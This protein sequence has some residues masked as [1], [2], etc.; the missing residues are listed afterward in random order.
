MKATLA[1]DPNGVEYYFTCTAGGGNDSGWQPGV[2]YTD[3][4]LSELTTYTYSVKARDKSGNLN[5]TAPSAALPATTEDG[6][7][8]SPDPMTWATAPYATGPTSVAMVATTATDVSDVEYYFTCTAGGGNDSG[9][10][11][12]STYIDFELIEL[13][14]YTYT[15]KA[16]DLSSNFNETAPSPARSTDTSDTT[17]PV[18]NPMTWLTVPYATGTSSISMTATT[19]SDPSGIEYYFTCTTAGGNDSGWQTS[20][21]YED[22]GLNELASYS[23][24][25]KARDLSG[26]LNETFDSIELSATTLDGTA[27]TPDPMTWAT[28]PHATG[29]DSISMTATIATDP[30]GIEYYFTCTA[31]GG[32]DSGWQPGATYEDTGLSDLTSYSYTA[33]A[34][35]LSI[36][37][38]ETVDSGAQSATTQDGTGPLPNAMT[39]AIPPHSTG[40]SS[41]SMTATTATDVSGVEYY[42]TC[43]AGGGNDSG[44]QPGTTYE[45][46]G[47]ND[48]T[49]Y[50]Y[51]VKARD[52]SVNLNETLT[53][54]ALS[55]T[56]DDGTPPAP[57]PMTWAIMPYATSATTIS[58]TATPATDPSGV[59]Y[60]FANINDPNHDSGWQD[61]IIYS[62]TGL[63]QRTMYSY[64][65]TARDKSSNQNQTAA[66]SVQSATTQDGS[67]PTP[68]PMTWNVEP[69]ADSP[70]SISM[71]AT[72]AVDPNGVEYY[73]AN[74]TD[75]AHD[76]G[77]QNGTLYLDAGLSERTEYTYTVMARDKSINQNQTAPS[78]AKSA[79]TED[80]TPPTPDPMT[81][82]TEPFAA[83]PYSI[84][85]TATTAS[86]PNGVQYYFT[87]TAGGG[88]DSG[89]QDISDYTD[90]GLNDLTL[91]T[92][93]VTARDKSSNL[94]ET[95]PSVA[96]SATTEDGTA[97]DPDPATWATAPHATGPYSISM[98][99]T[100]A[101]DVSGVEYY[102][103]CTAGGGNDSGWQPDATYED[104]GLND[105]TACTYTVK[106]RDL[107]AGLNETTD[108]VA[109]SATTEDGT[110]PTPDPM[111][112]AIPPQSTGTSS[113]SMTATTATDPS[114]VEY[115]FTCT[116]G[117]GNDSGWQPGETYEDIG[118]ND[119]SSYTYTVTARDKSSNQ[120]PTAAS[121]AQSA[122]TLDGTLP[123]P[124]PMT[125][126]T[127]PYATGPDS[128]SMMATTA[129]DLSGVEYY[130]TCTAGGGND[131][132]WQPEATY[133]DS[134][135]SEITT[136]TYT[137]SARDLSP[138]QNRTAESSAQSATTEDG[139]KPT[140][141][142][143][144]WAIVPHATST[145][146]ISMTA[147]TA[148]DASGVEY[149]FT[150]T[151]GGGNNSGWQPGATYE[152]TGLSEVTTYTYTVM[153]RD[154]S[155]NR[156]QT[157][158]SA[159]RSA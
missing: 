120:N 150:C 35:D 26:N 92:Y 4:G 144:T 46:T 71:T 130:F 154:L 23:Y 56:T 78:A 58:M 143:M 132:G 44:W 119:L 3:T 64:T 21:T 126:A 106:A 139:T 110:S 91:Y 53:S 12:S 121:N 133:V 93:T 29:P 72:T 138:N 38:N 141:N 131:S 6:T 107:S 109:L 98:T 52:L 104:T 36:N 18:P 40:T 108:S 149:Y 79:T 95:A 81:W 42:F 65:V 41:I 135:L 30:S 34:R 7:A 15:V 111:T 159:E 123:T 60:Y 49:S 57:D 103:T 32:N 84:S 152:D 66:S 136:Y 19:A 74:V 76:S 68:D 2:T 125:W 105:L 124:N 96:L 5:E 156:N 10:Q 102:F 151:A 20:S 155:A 94:N 43:T 97:P 145:T 54:G 153:A 128:I 70:T 59:E 85:M 90:T 101:T 47:L 83:G 147:T 87:C 1:T 48:L 39:W 13:T 127:V 45:D 51:T 118:L 99:A 75:P 89:W 16:R 88:N 37:F 100:T 134:D 114:G 67:A 129:T 117:G 62:D 116:A 27:P 55:A 80:G 22:T 77:W 24:T 11:S 69:Y 158:A 33:K 28:L 31:G 157:A 142:P 137:V 113:I 14:S 112:W 63:S 9:W 86:D 146:S 73:F 148:S 25:V 82:A 8:P 122:T 50:T 115:Y 17:A 61:G 140:P